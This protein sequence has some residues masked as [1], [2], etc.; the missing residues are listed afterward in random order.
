M[1]RRAGLTSRMNIAAKKDEIMLSSL[2]D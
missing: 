1:V 2:A